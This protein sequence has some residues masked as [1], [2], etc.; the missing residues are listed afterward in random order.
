LFFGEEPEVVFALDESQRQAGAT[1]NAFGIF[2][3]HHGNNPRADS[4]EIFI[5][6]V[7]YTSLA[8]GPRGGDF[9]GDAVLDVMD[10][11]LLVGGI[12]AGGDDATFDLTGDGTVDDADLT[13]WL[14]EAAAENGFSEAYLPGDSNL[15]G[16]VD[17]TDLNN[18]AL[19][20]QKQAD[21]WSAGDFTAD[22]SVSAPDLNVLAINWQRSIAN[23]AF[24]V[25][26]PATGSLIVVLLLICTGYRRKAC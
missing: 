24:A 5:D 21:G 11:D 13:T 17:A 14:S 9:N 19:N 2:T 23:V 15:D 16:S 7:S 25:P 8:E 4:M 12:V 22:G 3:G 10:L 18:L 6:D 26:E 1:L 20:W